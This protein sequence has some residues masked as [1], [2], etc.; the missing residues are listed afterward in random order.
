MIPEVTW[1]DLIQL[2]IQDLINSL[3]AEDRELW[4][5]WRVPMYSEF[6]EESVDEDWR[7]C[8]AESSP[9]RRERSSDFRKSKKDL[10]NSEILLT[11]FSR[12][13]ISLA[14]SQMNTYMM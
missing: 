11:E 13:Q 9:A 1:S 3:E 14:M 12:S 2:V 10:L 6:M 4:H 7:G 8:S 5:P